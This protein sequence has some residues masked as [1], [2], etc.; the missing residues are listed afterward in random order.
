MFGHYQNIEFRVDA[1]LVRDGEIKT[2]YG[3]EKSG[4]YQEIE[5]I[6]E[7]GEENAKA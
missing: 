1:R 4:K 5:D 2:N 6:M 7:G 3:V